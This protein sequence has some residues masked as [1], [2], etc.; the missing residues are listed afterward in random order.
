M[1]QQP[2]ATACTTTCHHHAVVS[3]RAVAVQASNEAI[4]CSVSRNAAL[5]QQ[6][7]YTLI[8]TLSQRRRSS[9]V[10]K[11][12]RGLG[13]RHRLCLPKDCDGMSAHQ[14]SVAVRWTRTHLLRSRSF[15]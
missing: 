3:D 6:D 13:M 15:R 1:T 7:L 10:G 11:E 8:E 5:Q 9:T 12:Q 2:I 4:T 14:Q